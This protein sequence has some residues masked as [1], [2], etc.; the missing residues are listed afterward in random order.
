MVDRLVSC[1]M[2]CGMVD[3]KMTPQSRTLGGILREAREEHG[4]KLRELARELD[5]DASRLSKWELGK[6]V[7]KEA[8]VARIL[9]RLGVSGE[10]YDDAI[11]LT[12]ND[13]PGLWV[14]PLPEQRS[15]LAALLDME[16]AAETITTVSP[17]M[18]PGL[19]QDY[20]YIRAVMAGLP[21]DEIST[22]VTV[23]LGRQN[24]I[25][26]RNAARLRAFVGE[27]A[28]RQIVGSRDVMVGQLEHLI[29]EAKRDNVDLRVMPFASGH[30]PGLIAPFT[31]FDPRPGEGIGVVVHAEN[32]QSGLFMQEKEDVT[33]FRQS[34]ADVAKVAMSPTASIELIADVITEMRTG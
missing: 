31:L 24:V 21:P 22:R 28:L 34:V 29:D 30:H 19:L 3:H 15:H 10:R 16:Q 1:H 32:Q 5:L 26:R 23:R 7:P 9:T 12:H 27:A 17:L 18:I 20:D 4:I 13:N 11:K 14:V 33:T 6:E 25:T 8:V 2:L